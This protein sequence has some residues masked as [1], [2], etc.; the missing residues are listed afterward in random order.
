MVLLFSDAY[1]PT[2]LCEKVL[3]VYKVTRFDL[4]D[5]ST[6]LK[7]VIRCALAAPAFAS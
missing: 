4:A 2:I 3:S 5:A 1:K 7:R 6:P